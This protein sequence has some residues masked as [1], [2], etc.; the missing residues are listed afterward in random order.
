MIDLFS[1]S[2]RVSDKL[3]QM[4]NPQQTPQTLQDSSNTTPRSSFSVLKVLLS[5]LPATNGNYTNLVEEQHEEVENVG[6]SKHVLLMA[7]TRTG[8]SFVGEFFNQHGESMFYLFEPLW[9][10]ERMLFPA[11]EAN[12]GTLLPEIYRDLL[13]A[14]FL[15]DFSPLE[16]FISPPPQDHVT[17]DLF[18]R[19]SSMALCEEPVCTP[20]IKDIFERYSLLSKV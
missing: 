14:L 4:H 5:K 17:P 18:R 9:H 15:C 12:N 8:S 13:Q 19:E 10:V 11:A 20:E 1:A 7:S 6:N 16:K 2:R 3:I